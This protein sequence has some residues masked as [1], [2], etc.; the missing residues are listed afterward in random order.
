M[1]HRLHK[2]DRLIFNAEAGYSVVIAARP[3]FGLCL[4]FLNWRPSG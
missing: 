3:K 2:M 4:A 1:N